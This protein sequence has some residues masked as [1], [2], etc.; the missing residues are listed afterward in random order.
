MP[1]AKDEDLPQIHYSCYTEKSRETESF[2]PEH[3]F[4]RILSG[5]MLLHTATSS[6]NFAAGDTILIKR[7]QFAKITRLP[8]A[9][10]SFASVSVYFD[11]FS[12]RDY[13][14]ERHIQPRAPYS[15]APVLLLTSNMLYESYASSLAAYQPGETNKGLTALKIK[16]ALML[17]L[18]LNT[19]ASALLFDFY[20]PEKIDLVDYMNSHFRFNAGI[21]RFAYLSGRSL[22]TFKRDFARKFNSSPNQWLQQRR[23]KE[24][25][26]LIK[27][28]RMKVSEVYQEVGFEDLSH[29]SFAFKNTY[30]KPP[31]LI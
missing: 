2:I 7:N 22:S 31:T 5:S 29:F 8:P 11:Q 16:E 14:A 20:A 18:H 30:G 9:N 10:G 12:L 6:Y 25:Y 3:T 23:L 28:K 24:A 21:D 26:Y 4:T 13:F 19:E 17:V 15:G 27:E 1:A